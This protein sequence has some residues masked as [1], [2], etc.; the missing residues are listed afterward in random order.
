M[1]T[2]DSNQIEPPHQLTLLDCTDGEWLKLPT[3]V[4]RDVGPA[5]QTLAGL[6]KITNRETYIAAA[7][8]A[9]RARLPVK[10]VRNHL[11]VTFTTLT[12]ENGAIPK[13]IQAML[14][15]STLA[16]TMGVYAKATE[17]AKRDAI[18]VLPWAVVA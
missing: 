6:L 13:A 5:A 8:I 2:E 14:G 7:E 4:M 9:L 10:T 15:H 1:S 11:R 3:A 12:L 17:K 18:N 16:L